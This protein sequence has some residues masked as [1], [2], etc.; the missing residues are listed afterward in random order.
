[1]PERTKEEV[2]RILKEYDE[3]KGYFKTKV[4]SVAPNEIRVRGYLLSDLI[5]NFTFAEI[6]YLTIQ[7][8]LPDERTA[9]MF[10]AILSSGIS[11][12]FI[13]EAEPVAKFVASGNPN[14][15]AAV[16]AGV[17]TVGQYQAG[18]PRYC[19]EMLM[20]AYG[21]VKKSFDSADYGLTMEEAAKR[22]VREARGRG[23]RL[24]GF[25]HPIHTEDPRTV[26]L[27]KLARK[28]KMEGPHVRMYDLIQKE[29]EK[30]LGRAMVQNTD[31]LAGALM[32]DMGF[33]PLAM[34]LVYAV[35]MI[36]GMIAMAVE[37]IREGTPFR[38]IPDPCGEYIGP[39][40]RDIPK[41]RKKT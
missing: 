11:H 16:A 35:T 15:V 29:L 19:A 21:M 37:E 27:R 6:M 24:P 20:K 14:A 41:S 36:P 3:W 38:V 9:A 34:E 17:L 5:G 2:Q 12:Y 23:E 26:K 30:D 39:V 33:D 10:E 1:M 40:P 7:G 13:D 32:A 31:G 22:V 4:S 28:L 18:A 8:E 25:G